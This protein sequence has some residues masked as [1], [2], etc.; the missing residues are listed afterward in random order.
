MVRDSGIYEPFAVV[1]TV[2]RT[3]A[4]HHLPKQGVGRAHLSIQITHYHHN[5][6]FTK[7][8]LNCVILLIERIF[9]H[10]I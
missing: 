8:L 10:Y 2:T 3:M 9:L 7:S 1:F 4:S 6:I 5:A